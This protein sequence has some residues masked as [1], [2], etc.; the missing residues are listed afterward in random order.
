MNMCDMK[1]SHVLHDYR[2]VST[3]LAMM[4]GGVSERASEVVR[5]REWRR[6]EGGEVGEKDALSLL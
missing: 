3:D 6:R 1:H 4:C 2:W 5:G